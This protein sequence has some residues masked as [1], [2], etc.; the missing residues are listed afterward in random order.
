MSRISIRVHL[1]EIFF[2]PEKLSWGVGSSISQSPAA[3]PARGGSRSL[4]PVRAASQGPARVPQSFEAQPI[5]HLESPPTK[6]G[7]GILGSVSSWS[8]G[9]NLTGWLPQVSNQ[10]PEVGKCL[11]YF[12]TNQSSVI[13]S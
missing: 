2:R 6:E 1:Q 13:V 3:P 10:L 9:G 7:T 5:Q 12:L 8:G 11:R 4:T